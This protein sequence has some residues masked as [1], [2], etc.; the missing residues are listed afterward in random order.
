[1]KIIK[2]RF[3][4]YDGPKFH[5][6]AKP[7]FQ[8]FHKL[9]VLDN[10]E[11]PIHKHANYELIT[12]VKGP[13]HCRLNDKDLDI[14]DNSFLIV[15]PGDWHQDHLTKGQQHYVLHFKLLKGFNDNMSL[16]SSLFAET[17]KN[18]DQI[19]TFPDTE[20]QLFFNELEKELLNSDKFSGFIQDSLFEAF[21]WKTIRYLSKTSLSNHFKQLSK[22]AEFESKI[23]RVF[24]K[25]YKDA[26]TV[27]QIAR[28]MFMSKRTLC[29]QCMDFLEESPSKAYSRY[30]LIKAEE[31]LL[32]SDNT[33]QHISD[34]IGFRNQN[35]FSR[36]FKD[37]YG[38]S[39]KKYRESL[40]SE[41]SGNSTHE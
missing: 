6:G 24:E 35:H 13:Y 15:K 18:N 25:F 23:F 17:V 8:D 12:V 3:Y 33:I 41:T 2:D 4:R 30:R 9:S 7:E 26:L 1:M 38:F 31:M 27:E 32:Y 20:F 28:K 34:K 11:Y 37:F 39:P 14:S 21:F 22:R 16:E 36:L 10:Y 19:G 29:Y 40:R 5:T